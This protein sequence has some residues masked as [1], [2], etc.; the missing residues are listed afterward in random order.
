ML[1][2][3]LRYET[4]LVID[5]IMDRY[6]IGLESAVLNKWTV[7]QSTVAIKTIRN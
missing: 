7:D 3:P 5:S 2:D 6:T 1:K 4:G